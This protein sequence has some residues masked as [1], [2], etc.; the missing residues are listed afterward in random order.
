MSKIFYALIFAGLSLPLFQSCLGEDEKDNDKAW[1]IANEQYFSEQ[2]ALEE[3]G[4]KIYEVFVPS[5]Q[6]ANKILMRWH[7]HGA[8]DGIRPM[9]NSTVDIIYTGYDKDNVNFDNSFS[10]RENGDSIYRV[11]PAKLVPGFSFALFQ[12]ER[13]DSCTVIIPYELAY[14]NIKHGS[15]PACSTL[16]FGIKLVGIPSYELPEDAIK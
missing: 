2:E 4:E 3:N 15:I 14:G 1:R 16:R 11:S 8:G 10:L 7:K 5:W 9:L 12:M 13:G 6:P